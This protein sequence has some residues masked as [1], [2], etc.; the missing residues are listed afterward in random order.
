MR[1]FPALGELATLRERERL[2]LMEF[3]ARLG[4]LAPL[5]ASFV[6]QMDPPALVSLARSAYSTDPKWYHFATDA[7]RFGWS[8][9]E[10]ERITEA[11]TCPVHLARGNTRMGG[12]IPDEAFAAIEHRAGWATT[13]FENAGHNIQSVLPREFIADLKA[14]LA[15]LPA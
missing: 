13:Y 9:P 5:G 14:F 11:V 4:E 6:E 1:I 12:L 7:E 10:A 2:S 3:A 15:G 8:E